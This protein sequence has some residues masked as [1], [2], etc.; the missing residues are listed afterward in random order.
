VLLLVSDA[1]PTAVTIPSGEVRS[2]AL[3]IGA[4]P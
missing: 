2:V 4:R 1:D 3:G